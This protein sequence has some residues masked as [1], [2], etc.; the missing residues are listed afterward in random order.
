MCKAD[1]HTWIEWFH[2]YVENWDCGGNPISLSP[3]EVLKQHPYQVTLG[4][5]N[6]IDFARNLQLIPP[7]GIMLRWILKWGSLSIVHSFSFGG[8]ELPQFTGW[9]IQHS[10]WFLMNN[11][12]HVLLQTLLKAQQRN[13]HP[14]FSC[15]LM[16]PELCKCQWD[17]L[18]AHI[19]M[20]VSIV[21]ET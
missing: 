10:L 7:W 8:R 11:S 14:Y 18:N 9:I 1:T 15:N 17:H 4:L 20:D 2:I 21:F 6:F 16:C 12:T 5:I 19:K 3:L 13:L